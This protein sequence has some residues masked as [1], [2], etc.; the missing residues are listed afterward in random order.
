MVELTVIRDPKTLKSFVLGLCVLKHYFSD[1][2][3]KNVF[4]VEEAGIE[5]E[6]FASTF[7]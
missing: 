7:H 5:K 2:L 6:Q 1:S 4:R 3:C